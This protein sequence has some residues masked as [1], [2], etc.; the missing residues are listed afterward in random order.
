M[1]AKALLGE[2]GTGGSLT[3]SPPVTT[4]RW[5]EARCGVCGSGGVGVGGSPEGPSGVPDE[6]SRADTGFSITQ[7][8][9]HLRNYTSHIC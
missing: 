6:D 8:I 7:D 9:L 5:P 2:V 3:L 1:K 4:P